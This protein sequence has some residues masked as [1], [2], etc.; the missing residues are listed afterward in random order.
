MFSPLPQK[1]KK[2]LTMCPLW[3]RYKMQMK[4]LLSENIW[5]KGALYI[6]L[7]PGY[8]VLGVMGDKYGIIFTWTY[9]ETA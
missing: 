7:N 2:V 4:I 5:L 6:S 9:L 3:Y 8:K 1:K